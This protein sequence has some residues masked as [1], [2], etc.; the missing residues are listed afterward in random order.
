MIFLSGWVDPRPGTATILKVAPGDGARYWG[1]CLAGGSIF[2]GSSSSYQVTWS[3]Q[4]GG[5]ATGHHG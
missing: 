3:W 2:V 5:S 1:D 4:R